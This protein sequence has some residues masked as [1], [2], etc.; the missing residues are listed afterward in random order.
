[1]RLLLDE[2]VDRRLARNIRGHDVSTVSELGWAG[3]RNDASIVGS[4]A[5][6]AGT[7]FP[8]FPN[9]GGPAFAMVSSLR[10]RLVN[11]TSSLPSTA[12]WHFSNTSD[13][14]LAVVVLRAR[15]NRLTDLEPLVPAL[16]GALSTLQAGKVTWV[17]G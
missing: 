8:Q 14:P 1:V 13:L 11:L 2:C 7:M 15:S 10:E 9:L 16:L 17:E 3:I 4:P 6:F 12:I 5:T